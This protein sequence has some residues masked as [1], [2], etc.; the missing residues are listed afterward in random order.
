MEQLLESSGG[1]F[2]GG[3]GILGWCCLSRRGS[4]GRWLSGSGGGLGTVLAFAVLAFA[5]FA[6]AV[7]AF[8]VFAFAVFP[9]STVC[10]AAITSREF[11]LGSRC[12]SWCGN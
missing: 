11:D 10:V 9:S 8:T 5:M 12:G 7:F 3:S 4:R 6:L 1:Y 2:R